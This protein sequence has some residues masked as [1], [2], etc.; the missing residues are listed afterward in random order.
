MRIG[1]IGTGRIGG[2]H[3]DTMRAVDGVDA[4]LV[5]DADAGRARAMAGTSGLQ[6]VPDVGRYAD[7]GGLASPVTARTVCSQPRSPS[8]SACLAAR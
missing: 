3:A 4:V 7:G 5:A 8:S 6:A 1:L 2:F